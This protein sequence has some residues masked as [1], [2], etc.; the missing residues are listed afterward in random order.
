M[1]VVPDAASGI[2]AVRLGATA[3]Q[4]RRP[5]AGARRLECEAERLVAAV[6]A[7]VLVNARCD[8]AMATGASGV[9]LPERDLPVREARALLGAR[10][11]VGRSVHSLDAARQA[12]AEGA[13]YVIFG[14]VFPS[15]SH[16]D[17]PP[18]GLEALRGVAAALA[19]PVL[20]I[21]GVD[22]ERAEACRQAGA[23]GFAAIGHFLRGGP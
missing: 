14:P 1:A 16:P 3:L 23:A 21:G 6:S 18:V 22:R 13:D 8:V 5:E 11:L 19:V 10:A 15:A 17:R 20:A 9:H 4:L 2:R 12:E 7:P